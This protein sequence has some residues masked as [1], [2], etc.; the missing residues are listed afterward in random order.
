MKLKIKLTQ[1]QEEKIVA[2]YL[3]EVFEINRPED[4]RKID[5]ADCEAI[6]K[7]CRVIHHYCTGRILK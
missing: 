4:C 5:R 6:Q 1:D 7:A 2:K 3:E